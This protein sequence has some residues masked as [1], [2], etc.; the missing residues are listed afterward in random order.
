[1]AQARYRWSTNWAGSFYF[2]RSLFW[3]QNL[4]LPHFRTMDIR[5]I[6]FRNLKQAGFKGVIFDKDNTITAPFDDHL[7]PS[8]E[9]AFKECREVF[10]EKGMAILSN[11]A[12]SI[13]DPDCAD[14][15]RLRASFFGV[16]FLPHHQKKPLGY[17][18]VAN[19]FRGIS[20]K[21][22]VM[23]GDRYATD[24]LFGNLNGLLTIHTQPLS[25]S[26]EPKHQLWARKLE[27]EFVK[28]LIF[29][30][31]LKAP[32]HPLYEPDLFVR[33]EKNVE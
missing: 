10:G 30:R 4:L 29:K 2:L 9:G 13:D 27:D 26:G 31:K 15:T 6:R 25:S 16:P 22:L 23:V 24:I 14:A 28:W 7:H 18:S 20:A 17:E 5:H 21:E 33:G 11:T 3:K 1:M 32:P 8:V 19:Y 12:G